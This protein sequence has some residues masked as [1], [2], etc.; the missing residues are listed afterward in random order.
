MLWNFTQKILNLATIIDLKSRTVHFNTN[1]VEHSEDNFLSGER[2]SFEWTLQFIILV[3]EET[4]YRSKWLINKKLRFWINSQKY[5]TFTPLIKTRIEMI[6][7]K[8]VSCMKWLF[9]SQIFVRMRQKFSTNRTWIVLSII[10]TNSF[11][12]FIPTIRCTH[13]N[14]CG[15]NSHYRP[16]SHILQHINITSQADTVIG[17]IEMY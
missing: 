3:I 9:C 10:T 13:S 14:Y 5:K 15:N 8:L 4:I 17:W 1:K 11:H 2:V 6:E 7:V 16:I 12:S